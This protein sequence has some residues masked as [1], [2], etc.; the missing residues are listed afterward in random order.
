LKLALTLAGVCLACTLPGAD[1]S[2]LKLVQTIPLPGVK[3]RFDHFSIDTK[4]QRLFVA[5]LGNDTLEV[6]DL[7]AAKPLRSIS[8]MSKPTGVLYLPQLNQI[9][10]ASGDH[11]ALTILSGADYQPV[12]HL[13]ALPDADNLRSDSIS[14][15]VWIGYG[16]GALGLIDAVA[17]KQLLQVKL[18]AHPESFQLESIGTRMFVNVPAA[19]QIIVIDRVTRSK[20]DSWPMETFQAGFPMALDEPNHRLFVGCRQPPR[21]IILDTSN[22]KLVAHLAVSRDSDDL[23]FDATRKRLY[24]SCGEGFIDI[25]EQTTPDVYKNISEVPTAS[26]ARTSFFSASLDRLYVAVPAQE[27]QP[28]EIRVFQPQ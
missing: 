24:L 10:V 14:N 17:A 13:R 15:L 7:A 25:I 26:G 18:P 28:A 11:G 16:D 3:G 19:K 21:L 9:A 5:A 8:G 12:H 20:S 22:G 6:I 27:M 4:A 1:H 2:C 23:F